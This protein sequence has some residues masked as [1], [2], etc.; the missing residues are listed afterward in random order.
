MMFFVPEVV[1]GHVGLRTIDLTTNQGM[2]EARAHL[3]RFKEFEELASEEK[4]NGE[5]VRAPEYANLHISDDVRT[6]IRSL[7]HLFKQY[8]NLLVAIQ[9][10]QAS[11]T[12][13]TDQNGLNEAERKAA[14][15]IFT[16][17]AEISSSLSENAI[18]PIQSRLTLG[19]LWA[20]AGQLLANNKPGQ[21]PL[22]RAIPKDQN[23]RP[24]RDG[25][26]IGSEVKATTLWTRQER[27]SARDLFVDDRPDIQPLV[28]AK[29]LEYAE[30]KTGY[31]VHA[32][33]RATVVDLK[34]QAQEIKVRVGDEAQTGPVLSRIVRALGFN[35]YQV[36]FVKELR[37]EYGSDMIQPRGRD[38]ILEWNSRQ[39]FGFS[40]TILGPIQVSSQRQRV[41]DPLTDISAVIL[42]NGTR[43]TND[44]RVYDVRGE[45]L[46]GNDEAPLTIRQR[47]IVGVSEPFAPLRPE[48]FNTAFES[49]IDAL[50]F[51]NVSVEIIDKKA[52]SI[53]RFSWQNPVY[54]RPDFRSVGFLIG[55]LGLTDLRNDNTRLFIKNMPDGTKKY[56]HSLNDLGSGLGQHRLISTKSDVNGFTWNFFKITQNAIPGEDDRLVFHVRANAPN[57]IARSMSIR[58]AIFALKQLAPLKAEQIRDAFAAGG[59]SAAE[60]ML[61]TAKLMYRRDALI[62]ALGTYDPSLL[63][64]V[65]IA[66]RSEYERSYVD[67]NQLGSY[68]QAFSYYPRLDP[69]YD[70]TQDAVRYTSVGGVAY[71]LPVNGLKVIAGKVVRSHNP[72]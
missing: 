41:H 65:P 30:P 40:V 25:N 29:K 64:Y 4:K 26:E 6:G 8:D 21:R 49:Q 37:V 62:H 5:S 38:L 15:E 60:I 71:S 36:D 58:D 19:G 7:V 13:R 45:L 56:W 1:N 54:D 18:P 16:R 48:Q 68:R 70:P 14:A 31:G 9:K 17:I 42:K 24:I 50:I 34:G 52:D 2:S 53:G 46:N 22:K 28:S 39:Q 57:E 67:G 44:G 10:R 59:Y 47:L 20:M 11:T 55:Y 43:I 33:F 12:S 35:T 63:A 27:P 3:K 66:R 32:G 23:G 51:R 72:R 69:N 61:F